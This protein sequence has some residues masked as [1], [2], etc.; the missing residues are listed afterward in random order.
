MMKK[1]YVNID[2]TGNPN[3]NHEV[4]AEDCIWLPSAKNRIDLG[5]FNSCFDAVEKAKEYFADI[6]GCATCCPLCHKA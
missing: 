6:D 1:Y 5:C 4:H 3:Y 2:S